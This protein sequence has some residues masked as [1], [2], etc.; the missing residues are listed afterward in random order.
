MGGVVGVGGNCTLPR[1]NLEQHVEEDDTKGPDVGLGR[2]VRG[3]RCVKELR[4]H[5]LLGADSNITG[6]GIR[7]G[8][9]KVRDLD[10]AVGEEEVLG[11]EITVK[12]ASGVT[13]LQAN[14]GLEE[15][16]FGA[17][18][19]QLANLANEV[20]QVTVLAEL[21]HQEEVV[22]GVHGL[23]EI[24]HVRVRSEL[25]VEG[26]LEPLDGFLL[27]GQAVLEEALDGDEHLSALMLPTEHGP[28]GAHGEHLGQDIA[29]H[30]VLDHR[31]KH[32]LQLDLI[33]RHSLQY[34]TS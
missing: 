27:R 22:R 34:A 6:K 1:V 12:D 19:G 4:A 11:L 5:V 30:L 3:E 32:F 8:E 16:G 9:A 28:V 14:E 15:E 25:A 24:A 10:V 26:E 13:V 31:L 23:E 2:G 18:W 7:G 33:R 21:K 17:V 29:A 20:K